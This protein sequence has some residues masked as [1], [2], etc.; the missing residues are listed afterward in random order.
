MIHLVCIDH[1]QSFL[2]GLSLHL[3]QQEKMEVVGC[4]SDPLEA[5]R[6]IDWTSVEVLIIEVRLK[7]A[8]AYEFAAIARAFNSEIRIIGISAISIGKSRQRL[9]EF[10][11]FND[12]VEKREPIKSLIASVHHVLTFPTSKKS[13]K[14]LYQIKS[15]KS[16]GLDVELS[17]HQLRLLKLLL[18][19]CTYSEMAD[20]QHVS[21]NTVKY[22]LK[23][24][25]KNLGVT[26]RGA[27][28]QAAY[29][30]GFVDSAS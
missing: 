20:I 24:L 10:D 14:F 23:L 27:A 11:L 9:K 17:E 15:A 2:D 25:Y 13:S 19:D 3:S 12:F 16:K 22:H 29:E 4:F 1:H 8:S 21:V 30:F 26:S 6:K 5:I 7:K 28:I 18:D